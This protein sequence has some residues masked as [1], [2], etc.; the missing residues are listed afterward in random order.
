MKDAKLLIVARPHQGDAAL[1]NVVRYMVNSPFA[2]RQ[3]IIA[4]G[5]RTDSVVHMIEDFCTAQDPLDMERHR[6]V[7]HMILTTRTSRGADAILEDGAAALREYCALL[8]HQA[9]L[10]PHYGSWGD[11]SNNHWHAAINPISYMTGQRLLDKFETYN[12]ITTYLN[13]NT[14]SAWTWRFSG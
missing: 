5:V 2:E 3:E 7:F 8:G 6:R 10:V 14:R 9:L 11:C 1:E 12:A 4:N 13:Q